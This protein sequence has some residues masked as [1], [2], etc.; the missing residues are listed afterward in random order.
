MADG[1]PKN[2]SRSQRKSGGCSKVKHDCFSQN[3]PSCKI[4]IS[5]NKTVKTNVCNGTA[6]NRNPFDTIIKTAVP[7]KSSNKKGPS[8]FSNK[9]QEFNMDSEKTE[10]LGVCQN[11]QPVISIH[12]EENNAKFHKSIQFAIYHCVICQEAR[13]FFECK[14]KTF[15]QLYLR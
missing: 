2:E 3:K 1:T 6:K 7:Q 5:E 15:I 13:P 11:S 8:H 14:I 10:P 12:A 4:K 9:K